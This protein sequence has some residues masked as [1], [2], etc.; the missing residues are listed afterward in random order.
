MTISVIIPTYRRPEGLKSCLEG[1]K[2]QIRKADEILVIARDTDNATHSILEDIKADYPNMQVL[3]VKEPGQVAALNIGLN[4]ARGDIVS[5]TDD[6]VIPHPD[7]L[8]IIEDH[9]KADPEIGGVGGRDWCYMNGR[10]LE[11]MDFA[12]GRLFWFGLLMDNHYFGTGRSRLVDHLKGANM[13]FRRKVLG[14]IYFDKRL[15]GEGAQVRNDLAVCLAVKRRGWKIIYDPQVAVDHYSAERF[16]KDRR[17][18]FDP[19]ATENMAFNETLALLQHLSPVKIIVYILWVL[20]VGNQGTPGLVLFARD[21]LIRRKREYWQRFPAALKGRWEAWKVWRYPKDGKMNK[22][23]LA[24][25]ISHP[26]QYRVPLYKKL[27]SNPDIDLTVYYCLYWG[28]K[29]YVDREFGKEIQWD[30]SLLEGYKYIFLKNWSFFPCI[31]TLFGIFNPGIIRELICN[32]FDAVIIS[33]YHQA[34]YLLGYIGAWLSRTPVF[35][36]A[37]TVLRPNQ[38]RFKSLLKRH[39]LSLIFKKTEGFLTI[40]TPSRKFYESFN[41]RKGRFFFAPQ[42]VDNDFFMMENAR[43]K[44]EKDSI[45]ISL[46]IPKDMPIILYVGKMI[47]RKRPFDLLCAYEKIKDKAALLLIGDGLL[48]PKLRH[49]AEEK[50]L[51]K[52][53]FAGFKNQSEITKYYSIG[54]V[55]VLPSSKEVSPLVIHEAMCCSLPIVVS[56]AIPSAVDFIKDGDNGFIFPCGEVDKLKAILSVLINDTGSCLRMGARS[57]QIISNWNYQTAEDGILSALKTV[58]I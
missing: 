9:F 3:K 2:K 56:D 8:K 5:F 47:A 18:K 51:S 55:F 6:D 48:L 50:G 31:E 34:S 11:G 52:V 16:D 36:R 49:Y 32:R 4:N 33:G 57:R 42:A 28:M 25:L 13:S 17:G 24:I 41:V 30:V 12:I 38:G 27:E 19:I 44:K 43:W 15:R 26:I 46:G 14:G 1:L 58:K 45:K 35:F 29:K 54:D 22:Y 10:L 39:I 7:W 21:F 40:N 53:I 23:K 37:E 20:L